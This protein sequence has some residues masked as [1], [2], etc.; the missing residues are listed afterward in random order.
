M[1][2]QS[3]TDGS[4]ALKD[5][6]IIVIEATQKQEQKK[7]RVAGYARV[8]SDSNDQLNSFAAQNTY[9]TKLIESNDQWEMVDVYADEGIS[10]RSAEKRGDFQRM[11]ADCERGKI[12]RIITKSISRFARN[13]KECLTIIRHL[14][15][16]GVSI[17]FEEQNIDT[18]IVT[19][20]MLTAVFAGLAQAESESIG[21]N[22]RWSYEKRMA[23]GEFNT[24]KSPLGYRMVKGQLEIDE[25]EAAIVRMIFRDYLSG[26]SCEAIG[27]K[28]REMGVQSRDKKN[29]W[30]VSTVT[31]ILANERYIG[32]ALLQKK[33]TTESFPPQ[34]KRNRGERPQYYV[35]DS[36]P[37][38]IDEETFAAANALLNSRSEK[39]SRNRNSSPFTQKIRCGHCGALAKRM[40]K[41]GKVNW[42][43][44]THYEKAT[45]C[46]IGQVP[47]GEIK[48]AFLRL[49]FKLKLDNMCLLR[50]LEKNLTQLR[51][52]KMLWSVD[53]I[54]LNKRI[55]D[56]AEQDQQLSELNSLGL[57]DPDFYISQKNELAAQMRQAKLEKERLVS[58]KDDDTL[59]ET[60]RI[61]EILE[62]SP[63][64]LTEFDDG[65]FE[66]LVTNIVIEDNTHLRFQLRNGL[67]LQETIERTMR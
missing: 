37:P 47:E 63:E 3:K 19:G 49:Y 58:S 50:E 10:G 34:K 30:G 39:V 16:I 55:S 45:L 18:S 15:S 31:Y 9:F 38:I 53:V 13:A 12:D 61:I 57:A 40:E 1:S 22:M 35:E 25:D 5:R 6:R 56:I 65:L 52:R 64:S 7:L 21:K 27:A 60:K 48:K 36:N 4:N 51:N 42:M 23:S 43:C 67:E 11:I 20:E 66:E 14:K 54:E 41:N 32:N 44:Y 33:Y 2:S 28:L 24:C 46:P 26:K 62:N 59:K 29:A 17:Y 8:S